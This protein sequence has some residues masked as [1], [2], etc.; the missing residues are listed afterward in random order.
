MGFVRWITTLVIF[1]LLLQFS[2]GPVVRAAAENP[3]QFIESCVVQHSL[4]AVI[5]SLGHASDQ[6][7]PVSRATTPQDCVNGACSGLTC[8]CSCHGVAAAI[9][10]LPIGFPEIP[11]ANGHAS[12][13]QSFVGI[14]LTPPARPPKI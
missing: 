10:V 6:V 13:Q 7:D 2:A 3:S 11:A 8:Q 9:P 12:L 4:Q 5:P 1:G 14:G